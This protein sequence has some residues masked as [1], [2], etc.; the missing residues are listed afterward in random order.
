MIS[1]KPRNATVTMMDDGILL[2]L[3]KEDFNKLLKQP[4][5]QQT[6]FSTARELVEQGKA[7]W[8]DVRL[9]SEFNQTHLPG[10]VNIQMRDMHRIAHELDTSFEYICCCDT[11]NRSS[12]ATFVLNQY[13]L[14]ASVL[15][16]GLQNVP[17]ELLSSN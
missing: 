4:N 8:I 14:Q 6:E 9:V 16:G 11:G 3:S 7:R 15:T 1:D 10:A 5:L 13:G 12:A 17:S 2:R